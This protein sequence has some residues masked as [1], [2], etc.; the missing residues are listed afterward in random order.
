MAVTRTRAALSVDHESLDAAHVTELLSVAPT[1]SYEVGDPYARNTLRRTRSHWGLESPAVVDSSLEDQVRALLD[2]VL[3]RRDAVTQLSREGYRLTWTCFVEEH[4][5]DGAVSLS[6]GLLG[7]LGV[8]PIDLW[9]D[10][11]ADSPTGA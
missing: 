10:T 3:G 8:L 5:G 1:E 11:Y 6:S 7:D 2:V 9:F 4:D